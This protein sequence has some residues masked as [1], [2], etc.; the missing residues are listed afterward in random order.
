MA[1]AVLV[2]VVCAG[3]AAFIANTKGRSVSGF[4]IAGLL[5]GPFG[6]VWAACVHSADRIEAER[7][8]A[9][10]DARAEGFKRQRPT[11]RLDRLPQM[12]WPEDTD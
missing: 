2:W 10:E 4:A 1:V 6:V 7:H 8:Q 9:I 5:L 11:Q 12:R 3:V